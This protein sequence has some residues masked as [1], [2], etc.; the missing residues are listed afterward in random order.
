MDPGGLQGHCRTGLT[1]ASCSKPLM[2]LPVLFLWSWEGAAPRYLASAW[3]D[4]PWLSDLQKG[5]GPRGQGTQSV[6]VCDQG[7]GEPSWSIPRVLLHR[8]P[9]EEAGPGTLEGECHGPRDPD[10]S[11]EA[12][13]ICR[14]WMWVWHGQEAADRRWPRGRWPMGRWPRVLWGSMGVDTQPWLSTVDRGGAGPA[15]VR[16]AHLCWSLPPWVCVQTTVWVR[17]L[18]G[19]PVLRASRSPR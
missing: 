4:L 15:C 10:H 17:G 1:E 8:S 7:Y 11:S 18:R 13:G 3:K 12:M 6:A 2:G 16:Q 9:A 5:K 19:F 14:G